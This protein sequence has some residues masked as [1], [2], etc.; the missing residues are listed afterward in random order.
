[1][2]WSVIILAAFLLAVFCFIYLAWR[3]TGVFSYERRAKSFFVGLGIVIAFFIVLVLLWDT[4]NAITVIFHFAFFGLICD[5]VF[6]IV[7]KLFDKIPSKAFKAALPTSLAALYLIVAWFMLHGVWQTNYELS[8]D[9]NVGSLRVIQ[10]ADSH[11]G[12][13]FSGEELSEYI[14]RMNGLN[15]DVILITGDFVDDDTSKKDMIDACKSLGRAKTEFGVYF[16]FGNHDKGYYSSERRGYGKDDLVYELEKNG[17]TVLEDEAVLLDDRFY[18]VGRKDVSENLLGNGRLSADN[19]LEGLDREKYIIVMDH[20]PADY[21]NESE[22]AADLVLSGHTHGGQM[23]PIMFIDKFLGINDFI[24]GHKRINNTDFI[25][26][27]GIAD[28]ALM[29]R[30]GSKSEFNVIDIE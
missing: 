23:F 7:A 26:S 9:K 11:I 2:L 13:T 6:F 8:T 25:V 20:Q 17:V 19:L 3:L 4:V 1:M 16:S 5:F 30:T 21:E 28:W 22:S 12:T 18:I 29:F 14:E 24:Y 27:S 15:P 10:F